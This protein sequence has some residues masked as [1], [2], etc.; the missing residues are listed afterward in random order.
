MKPLVIDLETDT[1]SDIWGPDSKDL[2]NDYY[3]IIYGNHPDKII[4]EHNKDGFKRIPTD[5]FLVALAQCDVII[6]H[7]LLFDLGY[8]WNLLTFRV[9]LKNG[10]CIWDTMYAEYIMSGQRHRNASLAELQQLYLNKK[11]KESR[12]SRLFKKGINGGQIIAAKERCKRLYK[13]YDKYCHDDGRTTLQIFAKQYRKA[14]SIKIL[15]I[16]KGHFRG[17]L[18]ILMMQKTGININIVGCEKTLN[19]F[20]LKELECLE[21]ATQIVMPFWDKKL[22]PFNINSNDHKSV[23][24]FGGE[25]QYTEREECGKFK[26]GKTKY[27]NVVK[28]IEIEGFKL[29]KSLT[30]EAK[31]CGFYSTDSKVI[32]TIYKDTTDETIKKYCKLQKDAMRYSKMCSTYL[33]AFLDYSINDVLYPNYNIART[34]TGRLSSSKPN[35]Q[36]IPASGE[37][38]V[39]IQGQLIAYE[40][41]RCVS[42]DFGQLEPH[43]TALL[44]Q[45]EK[46][47]ED[48]LSGI[49]LHCLALS[50]VPKLSEGKTYE[51]IYKLAKID[52]DP[53]WVLKRKKAKGINFKRA[54]GGGAKSLAKDQQLDVEIVQAIFDAQ[55]QHY[56]GVKAFNDNVLEQCNTH[57]QLSMRQHFSD[58]DQKAR[59][60][61]EHNIEILPVYSD[62]RVNYGARLH[63]CFA[64]YTSLTGRRYS[65]EETGNI[66]QYGFKRRYSSTETK[67]YMVQG[68]AH[69]VVMLAC[70]ECFDYCLKHYNEVK[71]IR[72]I[73]DE[74]G[75]YVKRGCEHHI[76]HL[77]DIMSNVPYTFK[78]YLNLNVAF[79]FPVE[80]KIGDNF[81]EMSVMHF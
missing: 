7:N 17:L 46:L 45:D 77:C 81:A 79:K 80:A 61:D 41:W 50:W 20:K 57:Q 62:D 56:A 65:F 68:S 18:G 8:L 36:N 3:T 70:G 22:K 1:G 37:M 69:D 58:S 71:M 16:L 26:N 51:E 66:T 11:I 12:I 43:C 28:S 52:E 4:V 42:I 9:W 19:E 21:Q 25:L 39:P 5:N 63:R 44:S 6:G 30:H 47:I 49:C 40:G 31:K 10:G 67:N 34:E 23:V 55:E 72:Q 27:K 74:L 48:L 2:K 33:Q 64:T 14:K 75:F 29:D 13:L 15:N 54:Y 32:N 59:K 73:H 78:K 35:M 60:F 76:K 38:F 24:L 53:K